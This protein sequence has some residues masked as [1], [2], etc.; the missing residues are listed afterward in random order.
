MYT[1]HVK[2]VNNLVNY[3]YYWFGRDG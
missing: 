2:F 1:I 3:P